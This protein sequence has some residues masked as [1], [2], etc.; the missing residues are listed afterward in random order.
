MWPFTKNKN[1]SKEIT[2]IKNILVCTK[3]TRSAGLIADF[4]AHKKYNVKIAIGI[5][6]IP[7]IHNEH[8]DVILLFQTLDNKFS[9]SDIAKEVAF[10]KEIFP[11]IKVIG[12]DIQHLGPTY[13]R[14][15]VDMFHSTELFYFGQ[16]SGNYLIN[17]GHS[18]DNSEGFLSIDK[19]LLLDQIVAVTKTH[20]Q[21][22]SSLEK[23]K[24]QFYD[25]SVDI[26]LKRS[27]KTASFD[28]EMFFIEKVLSN[29]KV[30]KILDAGCGVGR[31]SIPLAKKGYSVVGIDL[32]EELLNQAKLFAEREKL[33]IDFQ[34]G[35]LLN[36]DK[37]KEK[38]DAVLVMWHVVCDL[39]DYRKELLQNLACVLKPGGVLIFDF[40]DIS[41]N[42]HIQRNGTY[43]DKTPFGLYIGSVP[44][45]KE[46]FGE[47]TSQ[48]LS[49]I[50]YYKVD[51][52][53]PKF[54]VVAR[55]YGLTW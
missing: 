4:L 43:I 16:G 41:K 40:P 2:P 36:L 50:Q 35:N 46:I 33:N 22:V 7:Q 15:G 25:S 53:I 20:S 18:S 9:V 12:F 34:K 52:G 26:F 29:L 45:L 47:L 17:L 8:I 14:A 23:E 32:S 51:W 21:E 42:L 1:S 19:N 5:K 37:S 38:Y 13:L 30:R 31:I 27:E 44:Q 6:Q 10:C 48:G 49:D 28:K 55:G 11:G 24:S 3:N 39:K 54:V